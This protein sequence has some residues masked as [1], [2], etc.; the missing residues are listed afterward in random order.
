MALP[1]D[2]DFPDLGDVVTLSYPHYS[3]EG[4]PEYPKIEAVLKHLAWADI[5]LGFRT[6][7]THLLGNKGIEARKGVKEGGGIGREE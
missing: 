3:H 2:Y 6:P 5:L 7:K 4:V 1:P